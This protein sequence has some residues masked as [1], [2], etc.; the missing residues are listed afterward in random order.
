MTTREPLRAVLPGEGAMMPSAAMEGVNP[1]FDAFQHSLHKAYESQTRSGIFGQILVAG[2]VV[3]ACLLASTGGPAVSMDKAK[4][5]STA[6]LI[7]W[8]EGGIAVGPAYAHE[9]LS[10]EGLQ[11]PLSHI[12]DPR[13]NK[14]A[15]GITASNFTVPYKAI[16]QKVDGEYL[17]LTIDR[18]KVTVE[19]DWVQG[20]PVFRNYTKNKGGKKRN[21]EDEEGFRD[22]FA[23]GLG[24]FGRFWSINGLGN[25]YDSDDASV[26]NALNVQGI[27]E[28]KACF[29]T[30]KTYEDQLEQEV[31]SG[32]EAAAK[33]FNHK[34][35]KF[36]YKFIGGW[37]LKS[38]TPT[39]V[40]KDANTLTKFMP[41]VKEGAK[42]FTVD[43]HNC[44][45]SPDEEKQLQN[46]LQLAAIAH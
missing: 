13:V 18:S 5:R 23:K 31:E 12:P 42:G 1:D 26:D 19:V 40:Q 27:N 9:T 4:T 22:T 30:D 46:Q 36:H 7:A 24:E 39:A 43:E 45:V 35:S 15:N 41:G 29:T 34:G 11:Y 25:K 20:S 3:G 8:G 10:A 38:N 32:V 37:L 16:T 14:E 2:V 33:T 44:N 21:Y 17:D 28:V 6:T